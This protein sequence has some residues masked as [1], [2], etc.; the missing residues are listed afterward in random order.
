MVLHQFQVHYYAILYFP[1]TCMWCIV[2]IR[3]QN[4]SLAFK[5]FYLTCMVKL[6]QA[7]SRL[8]LQFAT[9]YNCCNTLQCRWD[10]LSQ[11]CNAL[12]I[13]I[14]WVHYT[15][16][17]WPVL[18]KCFRKS[19]FV[20]VD[21][22]LKKPRVQICDSST[23]HPNS[24]H[25]N[26]CLGQCGWFCFDWLGNV[27]SSNMSK[28]RNF[29]NSDLT[30]QQDCNDCLVQ[31]WWSSCLSWATITWSICLAVWL[32]IREIALINHYRS[33]WAQQ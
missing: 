26:G 4:W 14:N 19:K 11:I 7:R 9:T 1:I 33:G 17:C 31:Y 15:M 24:R 2:N 5:T 29:W 6:P 3:I 22:V 30:I 12:A 10:T 25:C 32:Q 18:F 27:F 20:A 28:W 21:P 16:L 23:I 13:T 8:V